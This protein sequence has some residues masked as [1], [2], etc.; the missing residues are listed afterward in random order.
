MGTNVDSSFDVDVTQVNST[1]I[2]LT[3]SITLY[4]GKVAVVLNYQKRTYHYY[5]KYIGTEEAV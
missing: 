5:S 2:K 1:K 4:T 3:C